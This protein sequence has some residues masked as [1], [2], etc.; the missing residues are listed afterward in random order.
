MLTQ[1]FIVGFIM[2][3]SAA[4]PGPDFAIVTKNALLYSRRAGIFTSLGIGAALIIHMAYCLLGL[5][6]VIRQSPVVFHSIQFLGALYL[7]YLGI[8]LLRA[9]SSALKMPA[10]DL[11]AITHDLPIFTA[12]RQGFF[13]NLFN[14]KATLF[15]LTFFTAI[16]TP[17]TP[18]YVSFTYAA[19]MVLIAVI[20][21]CTL[22]YLLSH[23][24]ATSLLQN[25]RTAIE[26]ILGLVLIGMGIAVFFLG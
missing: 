15:F 16:I 17:K 8:Q 11:R 5:A 21:F 19:E 24:V 13:C 2:L 20:W 3:C 18:F 6:A 22:S 26:K 10:K 1:F 9:H 4:L 14:P 7:I 23:P 12:F 25:A